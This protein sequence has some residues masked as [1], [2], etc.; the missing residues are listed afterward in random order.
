MSAWVRDALIAVVGAI[1]M[2]Q[3]TRLVT[4]VDSL[5][6]KMATVVTQQV[7]LGRYVD[8]HEGRLRKLEHVPH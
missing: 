5:N 3:L 2:W 4:S 8:D 1:S 7:Y 6:D